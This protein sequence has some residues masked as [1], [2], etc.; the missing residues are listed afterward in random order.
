MSGQAAAQ[1]GGQAARDGQPAAG[2]AAGPAAAAAAEGAAQPAAAAA[3]G[4]Q[5]GWAAGRGASAVLVRDVAPKKLMVEVS[6]RLPASIA[7][8]D[9][10]SKR[11]RLE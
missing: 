8:G 1:Q 6:F 9:A 3:R 2:P 10:A 11:Q 4:G 7:F 5:P